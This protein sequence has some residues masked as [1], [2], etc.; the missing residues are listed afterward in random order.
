MYFMYMDMDGL[1][2]VGPCVACWLEY[3]NMS[4]ASTPDVC[5]MESET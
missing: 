4:R 3:R 1:R 2:Q 5:A